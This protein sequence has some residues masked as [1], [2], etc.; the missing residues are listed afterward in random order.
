MIK[1]NDELGKNVITLPYRLIDDML[2]FD[3]EKRSLRLCIPS[4]IKTEVFRLAHD[5]MGYPGYT[6]PHERLID[7]LYFRTM[8]IK[9]HEFISY[10][11]KY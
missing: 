7:G 3:D 9:L 8:V 4:N 2:Y 1:N 5:E 10:C 6:K 11:P